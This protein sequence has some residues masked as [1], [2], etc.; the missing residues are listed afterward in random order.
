MKEKIDLA[1]AKEI[2]GTEKVFLNDRGDKFTIADYGKYKPN[3][4]IELNSQ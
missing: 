4:T 3:M 2:L 1:T